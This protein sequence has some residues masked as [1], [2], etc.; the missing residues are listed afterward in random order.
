[1]GYNKNKPIVK[2][3]PEVKEA[4]KKEE[5]K[6]KAKPASTKKSTP[7]AKGKTKGSKSGARKKESDPRIR[8]AI[9]A[10][11]MLLSVYILLSTFSYIIDYKITGNFG[12]TIGK[13]LS[14]YTFGIGSFY[15]IFLL[16]LAGSLLTFKGPKI[17]IKTICKYCLVF[18]MWT[19]LF[20]ATIL[21]QSM[22]KFHGLVGEKLHE[23]LEPYIMNIGIYILLFFFLFMYIIYTFDIKMPTIN[24]R[25]KDEETED[26]DD[27]DENGD[28]DGDENEGGNDDGNEDEDEKKGRILPFIKGDKKIKDEVEIEDEVKIDEEE[29]KT[30]NYIEDIED[31]YEDNEE[32]YEDVEIT[33][34]HKGNQSEIEEEE[35][36]EVVTPTQPINE[37]KDNGDINADDIDMEITKPVEE[38]QAIEIG[39]HFGL[40][41][42]FDPKLELSNFKFPPLDLLKEYGDGTSSVDKEELEAN[43]K[44]IVD[45]LANYNIAIDKIKATIGPTVTLYEIIPAAGVR[46]AKIKNLQ[47]DIALCLSA[48]GIRIIAPIPGKGTVGIEVPNQKPQTVSMK[49]VLGS[50]RFQKCGYELPFGVGKTISNESYVADLAKMPHILMAGA[51]GQGKSVGIN[52]II[53]SLLYSKHPAELKFVL[54]DPKKVELSLYKK[55]ERHYLAKLPDAEEAI[56]TDVR[57]VVRTLNSLCIEMDNRYELLKDAQVR[58]IKE[59]NAKFIAR[60]LNPYDGHRFLPYIVLVV[61]EFADLIMTAGKEVEAPIAR[62]AQLARAIGIHLIIATQRPSVNIITGSIKA[63]F[64]ARIAFRVISRVDSMT[65]LDTN[66]ADQLIGR[67]DM[68][69]STGNDLVRIQCAFIDTPE[70][71][72]ITDFIGSQRGYSEAYNLPDCPDEKEEGSG[73]E[74]LDPN[75]RD[76]LFEEAA[77][78][79]VQTQ[80][81]STSMLQRKLKLGYNRAGRIIDQLE[82]AGIVGPFAGSK[83][84]EVRIANEMALEQ[85]LKD[86]NLDND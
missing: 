59:Y 86:L 26:E 71:E 24:S 47:D 16:A 14:E 68:L 57:K 45:T 19:P 29:I 15:L 12:D 84:R 2:V 10:F 11:I 61:D 8:I 69:L 81:G 62:L 20:L 75:E 79:I 70:V 56:I 9:G 27:S 38:K 32:D 63:N 66:G 36:F 83:Q 41:T 52:A 4:E 60:K 54:V 48:I 74:I 76:P 72:E 22:E 5:K 25:K 30:I 65:I 64:P 82:K 35:G 42:N 77:L 53:S 34:V 18:L 31:D 23:L 6:E 78:I 46:I 13:F 37:V 58:N 17:A 55:I 44:R 85:H 49:S 50:E 28:G 33:V 73:K 51:T 40:D 43:K 1:M 39:E 7:K 67:G 21:P 3:E 80:Q